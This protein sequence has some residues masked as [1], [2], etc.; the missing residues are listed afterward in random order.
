MCA[1]P[2]GVSSPER[3]P[4]RLDRRGLLTAAAA[5]AAAMGG[6]ASVAAPAAAGEGNSPPRR[7]VPTDQISIQLYTLR[8]Q[9]AVDF[10]GTMAA[11][12]AIGYQR[13]EQRGS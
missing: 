5:T 1:G 2:S 6:V 8:N 13:V 12:A 3:T 4:S 11:L 7:G 9:L 10:A